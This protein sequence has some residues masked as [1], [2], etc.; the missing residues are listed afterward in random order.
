M[1]IVCLITLGVILSLWGNAWAGVQ[2]CEGPWARHHKLLAAL[3]GQYGETIR[4]VGVADNGM[5]IQRLESPAGKT[6]T[7]IV[8]RPDGCSAL[9]HSGFDWESLPP[10]KGEQS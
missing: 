3:H 4:G 9:V 8:T 10:K 6:W 7:L 1:K 5:I 2:A